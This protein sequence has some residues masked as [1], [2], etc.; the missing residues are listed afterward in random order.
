MSELP[1]I[2]YKTL[3]ELENMDKAMLAQ[4]AF[5]AQALSSHSSSE[6]LM[7]QKRWTALSETVNQASAELE[8]L[9]SDGIIEDSDELDT[10][11]ELLE[12]ERSVEGTLTV[13]VKITAT[14]SW[15][16]NNEPDRYD[17]DVNLS[18]IQVGYEDFEVRDIEIDHYEFEEL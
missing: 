9:I 7:Y 8:R 11:C 10:L 1:T 16:K 18:S 15:T 14:G 13:T 4:H 2:S 3:V 17:I 6:R 5:D 12:V